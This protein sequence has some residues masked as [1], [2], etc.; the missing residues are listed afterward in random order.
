MNPSSNAANRRGFL[1]TA[2]ATVLGSGG[3]GSGILGTATV[4]AALLA[5]G[6]A[7]ATRSGR[8]SHNDLP[9][10]LMTY[11]PVN[12]NPESEWYWR[13][14]R[15]AFA[16]PQD[17]IHMNTG[18]TGSPPRFVQN[19]LA[20]YNHYKSLDPRDWSVNLNQD[21]PDLF[22]VTPS[23][24][25]ARQA[26]VAAAYGADPGE[27][28]LSYNTTD[29]CNLIFAGT[30]WRPGDRIV[31]T[32]LEHP[33]LNGP[34][35]WA[36]DYHGVEVV[37][38]DIPSNFTASITVAEVLS[39]FDAALSRPLA[40]GARQYL[41]ISEIFY[42]NGVRMPVRE[43]CDLTRSRG[44]Y[45]IIDTA[46]GWG[47]LPINCHEY[48]ADF[49]CGAG[50][51]WL[52]GGPGTGIL[53]V[54]NSGSNLPPY[55][56]GNYY[57]YGNPFVTPSANFDNRSWSPAGVMQSRGESNT[58]AI[59]AMTDSLTFFSY[60][61]LPRIYARGVALG[62]YLKSQIA[63]R[64]GPASLWVQQNPDPAFHSFL[65]SFNPFRSKDD[66]G[67]YATMTAAVNTILAALAAGRP[68]INIRSITW[69]DRQTDVADNR[70]GLRISTHAMYN[71]VDEI[72]HVFRTL[73]ALIDASGLP[74]SR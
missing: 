21:L 3:I 36:R 26:A 67:A 73:A 9:D 49:I 52:C 58:P 74:Q 11:D 59:Y 2:G 30:P 34:I 39:W 4:G 6:S 64:W 27:I 45:S 54:R 70:I 43:L 41:A 37:M 5:P 7:H 23:A 14:V 28:V 38:V 35:A 48:G 65:T 56:T 16:L 31:T 61:G 22:P 47:M 19:N 63:G 10:T 20:V 1:R 33:A 60:I 12:G 50:H 46:H 55:A 51:K 29:A 66:P 71:G 8:W 32:N 15:R 40:S 53:Y 13:Q 24:V 72:D 69:R 62:N 42:K 57:L 44:G 17:Y 18:T 68:K 25:G